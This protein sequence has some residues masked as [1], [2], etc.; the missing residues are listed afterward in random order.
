[1]LF[2][3]IYLFNIFC[4]HFPVNIGPLQILK[5]KKG[6]HNPDDKEGVTLQKPSI[7]C[8]LFDLTQAM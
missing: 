6:E 2:I 1:M 8:G 4:T 7:E 5:T 3:I